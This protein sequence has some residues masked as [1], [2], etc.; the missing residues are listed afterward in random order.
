MI[1]RKKDKMIDIGEMVKQGKL[2]PARR[3]SVSANTN[4]SEFINVK[5]NSSETNQPQVG[6]MNFLN[7]PPV[8]NTNLVER[9]TALS[10]NISKIEQRLEVIEKKLGVGESSPPA[11]W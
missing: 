6:T 7:S 2:T 4:N 9:I 11:M 1:F 8:E 5:N 10:K 3:E